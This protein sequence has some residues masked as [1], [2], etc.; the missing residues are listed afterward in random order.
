MRLNSK[1]NF[2]CLNILSYIQH[3]EKKQILYYY[4]EPINMVPL[5]LYFFQYDGYFPV[6]IIERKILRTFPSSMID[7][8]EPE[9]TKIY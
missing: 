8:K 2:F 9:K 7:E 1:E 4:E 3:I 5:K 6:F